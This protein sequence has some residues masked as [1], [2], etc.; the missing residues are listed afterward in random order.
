MVILQLIEGPFGDLPAWL[1]EGLAMY[2]EGMLPE[3]YQSVLNSA[4]RRDELISVRS[5]SSYSGDTSQVTIFYAESWSVAK[6]LLDTYGK[7]KMAELLKVFKEG[8]RY[9]DALQKVYGFNM[10]GLDAQWR[11]SLGVKP[12][13]SPQPTAERRTVPTLVPFGVEPQT[14]PT[15]SPFAQSSPT[16]AGS[17]STTTVPLYWLYV[18]GGLMVAVILTLA[19]T[20]LALRRRT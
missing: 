18:G 9:D 13:T 17:G 8:S 5:L 4:I 1:D 16:P 7:E 2:A 10:D 6:Y 11:T 20:A 15:P 12:R 19:A 14:L 3:R